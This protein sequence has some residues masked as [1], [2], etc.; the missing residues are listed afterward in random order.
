MIDWSEKRIHRRFSINDEF[1][2]IDRFV[3]EYVTNISRSGAF[4]KS[5]EP[6]PV[7]TEVN[8][9][10]S[11]MPEDDP[12]EIYIIEGV[13]KVVRVVDTEQEKGMGVLFTKLT[14]ES[15]AVVD[16]LTDE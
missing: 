9:R 10:F 6:L 14:K 4:I 2:T 5:S 3:S 15:Q 13:G 11:V 16:R 1:T 12:D 7:G 8:L